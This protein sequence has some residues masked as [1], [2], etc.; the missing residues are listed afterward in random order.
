M[1]REKQRRKK[2]IEKSAV[3]ELNR[4]QLK[5][6]PNLMSDFSETEDIRNQSYVTYSNAVMLGTMYYKNIA[7]IVSMQ[8][9]VEKFNDENI[10]KN[11]S[12]YCGS[13][14]L[15]YLPHYV[16]END[17]LKKIDPENLQKIQQNIIC[18]MIRR[19]SFE[20]ARFLKKW[21]IMVDG[22]QLYSGSRQLNEN[23]LE[24]HHNKGTDKEKVN[25]YMSVLEAKIYFGNNLI[26]SIGSEFIE[27]NGEDRSYQKEMNSEEIKQDCETKAFKRLAV[28]LKNKFCKLP[29]CLLIDS[30]Y[31]SEP[32]MDICKE[33]GWDYII[34]FKDG[35]I[36]S[37]AA[38]YEA[39]PE[40][41]REEQS[42]YINEI[43]YN[44]HKINMLKYREVKIEKSKEICTTFQWI[45]NILITPKNAKKIALVGRKRWK[46]ENQGFNRQKK[47]QYDI[48][49]A[50]SWDTNALKCH[51]LI[52][53]IADFFKQ[54]YEFYFLAINEIEKKQKNISSDLFKSFSQHEP[55]VEDI[56][57]RSYMQ[58]I[59]DK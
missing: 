25:Y 24:R 8:D 46:I 13:K 27:N 30:L 17:Y 40:K 14:D 56:F 5:F 43:D 59:C 33:N 12:R 58:S 7:G 48:T 20:D 50:C 34:R 16:T 55:S 9:M 18:A 22:T 2:A 51:Y 53:Q 57:S 36:P 47:W 52:T 39:I 28:K 37:I 1:S 15:A 3:E 6:Y 4:I 11:V 26:A 23:C 42:E 49:H 19:R 31:A 54:L 29:M 21:L 44:G 38:E 35:S 45:T 41:H 10:S 32:V